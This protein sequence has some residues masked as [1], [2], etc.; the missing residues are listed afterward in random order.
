VLV[1]LGEEVMQ[2]VGVRREVAVAPG[3]RLLLPMAGFGLNWQAVI[4]EKV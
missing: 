4:L 2:V 3:A 1:L